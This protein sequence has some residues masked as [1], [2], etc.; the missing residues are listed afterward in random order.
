MGQPP[1]A[2]CV[3]LGGVRNLCL[4]Q[5][6]RRF[7]DARRW[8]A[9]RPVAAGVAVSS[10]VYAATRVA[11]GALESQCSPCVLVDF[12][13]FALQ[14]HTTH[15]YPVLAVIGRDGIGTTNK[16]EGGNETDGTKK[17]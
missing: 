11:C 5:R 12:L 2:R 17:G 1:L 15:G 7:V 10:A 13:D 14:F 9:G 6:K 4:V 3:S 8:E 16:T